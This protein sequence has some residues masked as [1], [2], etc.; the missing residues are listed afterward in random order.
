M[1]RTRGEEPLIFSPVKDSAKDDMVDSGT[2]DRSL[3]VLA[4]GRRVRHLRRARGLTLEQLAARVG[5]APSQLSLIENGRREPRLTLL[6][7]LA[8]ALDVTLPDLLMPEPPSR[9]AALE[10][11]LERAQRG[12]VYAALGLPVVRVTNRLP[13]DVI[14]SLVGL[15]DELVRRVSE[16]AAT[17]EEA[18]RANAE[19]R[20]RMREQ[21]NYFPEVE[22]AAQHLLEQVGHGSGPVTRRA[23]TTMAGHLGFTLHHVD[24]LPD[25]T[26]SVADLRHRR[27]Y[28][29]QGEP[30]GGHDV[31]YLVLQALGHFVLGH[32][33]PR[34]F[35]DFL[36]QRVEINY[37]AAAILVPERSA[38]ELLRSAAAERA[39]AIEDLRDAYAVSYETAAHRFTN[40]ATRHLNVPVHFLRVHRSGTIYKAYENDGIRFP[41]DVTGAI[42]GQHACRHWTARVVFRVTDRTA[43]YC[44]YTDTPSGTYWCTSHVESSPAGEFSVSVGMPYAHVRWMRGR[45]TTRRTQS[46]CPDETCCRR[47]P[48]D[49]ASRWD[50]QAWPSARAHSHL[51]AAL[52]P[53][54][55][56]GVD[57]TDVYEFLEA[58]APA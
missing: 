48:A 49:L 15:H 12:P 31:R 54:A 37:F 11:A 47:P 10:I 56:P 40:L 24:D 58:R 5:R 7:A 38:V 25:S 17:P 9:R 27:I 35:A 45:E 1:P 4:I 16:R 57:D 22:R 3:D 34:D 26:R 14:R 23:L 20:Q 41:M 28:L 33:R 52:P 6:Q 30:S 39:V 50:G 29:P 19:L 2:E 8:A 32:Q 55:F 18:R 42:E 21:G 51:L 46:R 13:T 53:G 43:P 44:Q 36:R